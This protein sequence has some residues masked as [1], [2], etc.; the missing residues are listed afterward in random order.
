MSPGKRLN[1]GDNSVSVRLFYGEWYK[2]SSARPGGDIPVD[3]SELAT[4]AEI[5]MVLADVNYILF[6]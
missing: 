5:M 2:V 1:P 6:K 3:P 4:R